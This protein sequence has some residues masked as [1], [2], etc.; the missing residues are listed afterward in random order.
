LLA[1][2]PS[3]DSPRIAVVGCGAW[4]ANHVRVWHRLGALALVCDT[5]AARL[6]AAVDLT[7]GTVE[8]AVS[9]ED[10]FART[11]INGVVIA[12]PAS[13][14]AHLASRALDAGKHVLVEKPLALTVGDGE[15]LA[16]AARTV[17]RV[18][19]VGHVLEYHPAFVRL[20][21]LLAS[22]ELGALRYLYSNRLNLGQLRVEENALWSFAPHDVAMINRLIGSKV[23]TV[24]CTGGSYVTPGT[25]DVTVMT[26]DYAN[27]TKAH[28]FVS[29][30]HPFKEHR[31]VAVGDRAMAVFDDTA[32][33]PDKLVVYDHAVEF[34]PGQP[35]I[36]QKAA[37]RSIML[38]PKEPL[39]AECEH[40]LACISGSRD[41]LTDGDTGVAVLRVLEAADRSLQRGGEPVSMRSAADAYV[42]P[43]AEVDAGAVLGPGST[44]W[45]HSHVMAGAEIGVDCT[46]GQNVFVGRGVHIGNGVRI[47]NNVSVFEGVTLEDDVFCG[48]S[49]TFTNVRTPR[50][51]VSRKDE[52]VPTLVQ[53][54]ATLGANATIMCGT[55]VGRYAM[56]GAGAV[57]THDVAPHAV[58]TGVPARQQ[59]WACRCGEILP[60]HETPACSRCGAAY[61][62]QDGSLVERRP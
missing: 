21:E 31:F 60:A 14:H 34:T 16:E 28:V 62:V 51:F 42:H 33:W 8:G 47:Q 53:Q 12:A 49:V 55:T 54:G 4:G 27:G 46:L 5:D 35:P 13:A 9:A 10:V 30:L 59:G 7:G 50:S 37:G 15:K 32:A 56:V 19:L 2:N 52:F 41:P 3:S 39:E 38:Q 36:A 22:G 17:G 40:F 44:V 48:P 25:A 24:T 6:T 58:V 18:L 23:G 45:H 29:W 20:R 43:T 61:A 11:D 57:V 26:L 1:V